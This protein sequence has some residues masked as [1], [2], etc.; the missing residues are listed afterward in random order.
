M[1]PISLSAVALALLISCAGLPPSV[2][3]NDSLV[4]GSFVLDF[5]KGFF[6]MS[7][8]SIQTGVQLNFRDV[9][10]GRNFSVRTQR[11]HFWFIAAGGHDYTLESFEL[12]K[13]IGGDY[14]SV[15]TRPVGTTFR[16]EKEKVI[17]PGDFRFIFSQP[18]NSVQI[19]QPFGEPDYHVAIQPES[20]VRIDYVYGYSS[21]P[22]QWDDRALTDFMKELDPASPWSDR[23]IV[24]VG[25]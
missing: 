6:D 9:T 22:R 7:R 24:D 20:G 12:F 10:D 18:L 1:K 13:S 15:G 17:Y 21:A 4:I 2:G 14:Y 5:P 16:A 19:A 8:T 11:G 3:P 25:R 23:E